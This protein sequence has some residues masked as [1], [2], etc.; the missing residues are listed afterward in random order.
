MA[1]LYI[2]EFVSQGV[3]LNGRQLPVAA[4]PNTASQTVAISA[5]SAS[6]GFFQNNTALVRLQS[7]TVCSVVV[8]GIATGTSLTA[9]TTQMRMAAGVAEYFNIPSGGTFKAA[10]IANS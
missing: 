6:S 5:S 9:T 3:D 10:V 8:A 2:T 7:D 1:V 4:F